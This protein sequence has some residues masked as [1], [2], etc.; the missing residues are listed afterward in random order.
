MAGLCFSVIAGKVKHFFMYLLYETHG[1]WHIFSSD[2]W[3]CGGEVILFSLIFRNSLCILNTD[4]VVWVES[5]FSCSCDIFSKIFLWERK[6]KRVR[7]V[8]AVK[9]KRSIRRSV[10][11][12][13]ATTVDPWTTQVW[14]GRVL[15]CT[16]IFQQQILQYCTIRN[17]LNQL[18]GKRSYK[19]QL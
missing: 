18:W 15:L 14:T 12:A 8:T 7:A 16:N 11:S 17:W 9:F 2:S 6:K 19:G 5:I 13:S 3:D 10:Y 1:L 4:I